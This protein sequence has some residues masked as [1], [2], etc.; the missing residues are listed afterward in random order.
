MQFIINLIQKLGEFILFILLL[1]LSVFLTVNRSN[2]HKNAVGVRMM[3][4]NGFFAERISVVKQ[5]FNSPAENRM[6]AEE[7]ARLLEQLQVHTSV[8]VAD[9]TLTRVDSIHLQQYTYTPAELVDYS[10]R[11]K[12]NYFLINKGTDDGVGKDMAVITSRGI[13]GN[14]LSSS[15]KYSSV[16]SVLHSQSRIR[17]RIKGLEYLGILEWPGEDHRDLALMEM[18]KYLPIKQGDTIVTAGASAS[19]PQGVLVGYISEIVPN[20][21]TGDFDITVRMFQDLATVKNV[22]V[23]DNLEKIEIQ[24][25]LEP[26]E[27]VDTE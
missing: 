20:E 18:P 9:T 16:I 27:N 1:A 24:Q 12:D 19:Y 10:L 6:L 21:T 26:I 13:V 15:R 25:A 23:V 5:F 11:K 22:Y 7:N 14:V 2:F 8:A 3:A 17:A 4:V